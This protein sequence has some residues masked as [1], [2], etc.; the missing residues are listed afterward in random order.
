[1]WMPALRPSHPHRSYRAGLPR[2]ERE[3]R[4]DPGPSC[5]L[6]NA[7]PDFRIKSLTQ[8]KH[9]RF[10]KAH[11]S[12]GPDS[13]GSGRLEGALGAADF[14]PR[15]PTVRSELS[16]QQAFQDDPASGVSA[17]L[18]QV[19]APCPDFRGPA[20]WGLSTPLRP[21]DCPLGLGGPR[22]ARLAAAYVSA[23]LAPA[24]HSGHVPPP[25]P[26]RSLTL[27]PPSGCIV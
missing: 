13:E 1:M 2:R 10:P 16:G 17:H 7:G 20:R 22:P 6:K 19:Q 27:S 3:S 4:K 14:P 9:R 5:C 18:G 11:G 24:C 26:Y 8:H 21:S 12:E 25:P 15:P 23:W